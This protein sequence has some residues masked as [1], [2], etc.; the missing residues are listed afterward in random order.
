MSD[1][2]SSLSTDSLM[3]HLWAI[4]KQLPRRQPTTEGERLAAEHVQQKLISAGLK[5]VHIQTFKGIPT[6]GVNAL[7]IAIAGLL[8]IVLGWLAG[9]P[10]GWVAGGLML[11]VAFA[12]WQVYRPSPPFFGQL[13]ERWKS[14]NVIASI[15]AKKTAKK[16][17]FLIGHLDAQ[18]Q[19]FLLP[20]PIPALMKPSQTMII[21]L[22]FLVGLSFWLEQLTNINFFWFQSITA[23]IILGLITAL[24]YD[25]GQPTVEGAN[26]NASAMSIL[27][28]TGEALASE[29]LENSDVTL[30][31]TGCEEVGHHGLIAYLDKYKPDPVNSYW[32]DLELVGTG[33]LCYATRHGVTYLNQYHPGKQMLAIAEKT[34]AAHPELGFCGRDMLILEEIATLNRYGQDGVCLMGY[35]EK[36]YLPNWHRI[37]DDFEHIEPQTLQRAG[38]FAWEMLQAMNNQ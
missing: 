8:S 5:D 35:D 16:H 26:D 34:A 15:P 28:S 2:P 32:I 4:C 1:Y 20:P 27:L 31:F 30:L 25:E 3:A 13:V 18:K 6:I 23:L 10:G 7:T 29:P 37:T 9:S 22:P 12:F 33:N 14:W 21:I 36:G 24:V 38:Y 19:R 17:I 11:V